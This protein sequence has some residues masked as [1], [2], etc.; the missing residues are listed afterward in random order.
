M[1]VNQIIADNLKRLRTERNLSMGQLAKLCGI[2]KVMLSQIEKGVTNPT[3]NTLWKI[4]K[5]LKVPYTL[6]LE[7]H[8]NNTQIIT[9]SNTS[10]QS[11]ALGNYHVFCYYNNT[12]SRNFEWFQMELSS[13]HSYKSIGHSAKTEEYLMVIEGILQLELK[14]EVFI[15]HPDDT[16]NFDA[17]I[18]HTYSSIGNQ[19]LKTAIINYYPV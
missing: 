11:D 13:G 6:L 3:I 16:I 2:S 8:I 10:K 18:E 9:K 14:G 7:E 1:E 5:G 17:S 15:L 12:P 19:T 4:A